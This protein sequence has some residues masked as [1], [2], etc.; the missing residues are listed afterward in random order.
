MNRSTWRD[1]ASCLSTRRAAARRLSSKRTRAG[2]QELT[3]GQ[4]HGQIELVAGA[5]GEEGGV[6]AGGIAGGIEAGAEI[7]L[8]HETGVGALGQAAQI[9]CGELRE[10]GG[11]AALQ[12]LVG[13][14]QGGQGDLQS[15]VFLLQ[16]VQ[17]GGQLLL[18]GFQLHAVAQ[19]A[20]LALAPVDDRADVPQPGLQLLQLRLHGRD[21][22][23]L[24]DNDVLSA[25]G[26]QGK[27]AIA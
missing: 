18:L 27:E 12:M 13:L 10:P 6:P 19:G 1:S 16:R 8:Q 22:L 2:A 20:A 5:A 9:V 24:R 25:G 14:A 15:V 7:A 3:H 4:A 21:G 17:S 11:E 23:A 26:G